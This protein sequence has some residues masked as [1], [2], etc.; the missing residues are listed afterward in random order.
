MSPLWR[1]AFTPVARIERRR[2][3]SC[4][5]SSRRGRLSG[6]GTRNNPS[7]VHTMLVRNQE[8]AFGFIK[9]SRNHWPQIYTDER[10]SE[11][12]KRDRAKQLSH[13]TGKVLLT[14]SDPRLSAQICG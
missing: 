14:F 10:G 3:R 4:P 9:G 7:M 13:L 1:R 5:A 8:R 11:Q 6:R 2:T 12:N